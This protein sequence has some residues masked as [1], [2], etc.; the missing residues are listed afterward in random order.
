MADEPN[1][2]PS[3][4]ATPSETPT[5]PPAATAPVPGEEIV[6]P[7]ASLLGEEVKAPAE[8]DKPA[9]TAEGD[10]PKEGEEKPKADA[11]AIDISALK[12]PEGISLAPGA[13][14]SFEPVAKELGLS[15]EQSQRLL[16]FHIETMKAAVEAPYRE[17]EKMRTGWVDEVKA[18]K[19]IGGDKLP[20]VLSTVS[21]A[22]DQYGDPQL[23]SMLNAT[24]AGDNPAV[25]RTLY[26]MSK[27]LTEGGLVA[28]NPPKAPPAIGAQALY[29]NHPA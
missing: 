23:R 18:D 3:P 5:N 20:T 9:A 8:G 11:T 25:I 12:I 1:A 4:A 21:K 22:L 19:E 24:G 10:A 6:A 26:R 29:P 13:L 27:A 7:P 17:H 15:Q 16:D 2:T 14:E 28:G